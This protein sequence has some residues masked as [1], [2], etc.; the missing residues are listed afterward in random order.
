VDNVGQGRWLAFLP[1]E[2]LPADTPISVSVRPGTPSAEGPLVTQE[3]QNFN[4]YTYA[5]LR[6]DHHGC[7]WSEDKCRPLSPFFIRFNNP[8]DMDN[9]QDSMLR[10]VPEL[11]GATVNIFGD[12]IN[13]RGASKGQTTYRITVGKEVQDIFGQKLGKDETLTFRVGTADPVLIGPDEILVTL[14]P[15]A[16]KP[17]LSLY[18]INYNKLDLKV[19]AVEPS[20]WPAFKEYLRQYQR[21]DVPSNPPG[22]LVLDKTMRL[23][24][25]TD[26]L[27]EVGVDLSEVMQGE[28]GH[29]IV[30]V[31]PPKGFF[32]EERYWETVQTWVQVT[33]IG[34]DAFADHSEMMVWTTALKDGAPLSEVT[35]EGDPARVKAVTGEDGTVRFPIPGAG[36]QYLV[37]SQGQDQ[38]ILPRSTY[39]WGDDAW[40]PRPPND[41]LRWYVFDDRQVYKP[42][43]EVH[44]K[45]WLRRV[46]GAQDGDVGL[47]GSVVETVSYQVVGPQGNEL[48]SGRP[49]VNALGGFNFN[50]TLPE[51]A[52]LGYAQLILNAQG[53]LGGL[54]GSQHYHDFQILEF[55]RPE[56]E[57]TA[58]NETEGPYFVGEHAVVAVEAKYYAG[59]PLPNA[60]VSWQVTSSP[61]NYS[62]P[63]WPDFI[64]GIWQPWWWYHEPLVSFERYGPY[65]IEYG[66][67]ASTLRNLINRVLS[68][69]WQKPRS[70]TSTA[71]PGLAQPACWYTRPSSTLDCEVNTSLSSGEIRWRSNSSS[72]IWMATP[73]PT[74]LFL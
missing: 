49:Q 47:V 31:K 13:I 42:G 25:P 54:D 39:Y 10:I 37:A 34:L 20:D 32:E 70:L 14:D 68:A 12:T 67:V 5:P 36:A 3:E 56:F 72:L 8:L 59:G 4:F 63:N 16:E 29:F 19:Y 60:E 74:G 11:P 57:V 64:F 28:F 7:S 71:R 69:C 33:Q 61:S 48:A 27:T 6:I 43:E 26:T 53:N 9:Y 1:Q 65:G 40:V 45:G 55:R 62:P 38:A 51:N 24:T 73:S 66:E 17:V 41:E 23:E 21:T 15:A 58:R 22:R 52:N 18:T 30:I 46:G 2:P 50:F 44:V 35:I